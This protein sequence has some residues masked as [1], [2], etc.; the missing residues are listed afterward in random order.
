ML[1]EL[2][3]QLKWLCR[4]LG[5]LWMHSSRIVLAVC[6]ILA[7]IM[8]LSGVRVAVALLLSGVRVALHAWLDPVGSV[9]SLT[10]WLLGMHH[11]VDVKT[12]GPADISRP[13]CR[14]ALNLDPDAIRLCD[15]RAPLQEINSTIHRLA[16]AH[17]GASTGTSP[18][19]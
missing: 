11:L 13:F 5:R 4:A 6:V 17:R 19:L 15:V 8:L 2:Y 1:N 10:R 3:H 7:I 12:T 9:T 14:S 18:L 16:P